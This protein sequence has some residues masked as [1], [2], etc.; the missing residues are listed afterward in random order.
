MRFLRMSFILT[1]SILIFIGCANKPSQKS[2]EIRPVTPIKAAKYNPPKTVI[3]PKQVY[4]RDYGLFV[5]DKPYYFEKGKIVSYAFTNKELYAF[6]ISNTDNK[7]YVLQ[8]TPETLKEINHFDKVKKFCISGFVNQL[9]IEDEQYL[10]KVTLGINLIKPNES[11]IKTTY[12]CSINN[13][14]LGYELKNNQIT[15]TKRNVTLP[16]PID[17][18][19]CVITANS[20]KCLPTPL[21]RVLGGKKYDIYRGKNLFN[22]DVASIRIFDHLKEKQLGK[23]INIQISEPK[24]YTVGSSYFIIQ[25]MSILTPSVIYR[26]NYYTGE[27]QTLYRGILP[28]EVKVYSDGHKEYISITKIHGNRIYDVDKWQP[29]SNPEDLKLVRTYYK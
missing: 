18:I 16:D 26:I 27:R 14:E 28:G 25:G 12:S 1:V 11:N 24:I 4:I 10:K 20:E 23:T 9:T 6:A 3:S 8:Y 7:L 29:V 19:H 15:F 22:A 13:F 5:N 21:Y 2:T 17:Q